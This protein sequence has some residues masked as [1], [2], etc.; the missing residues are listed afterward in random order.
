MTPYLPRDTMMHALNQ[1]EKHVCY[2]FF[3]CLHQFVNKHQIRNWLNINVYLY[4]AAPVFGMTDKHYGCSKKVILTLYIKRVSLSKKLYPHCF[5]VL[6]G[7]RNG[8]E[9]D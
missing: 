9:H 1:K 7:P 8:F 6:V 2:F 3:V 5:L 4:Q